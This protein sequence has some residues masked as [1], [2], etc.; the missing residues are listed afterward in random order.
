M[1]IKKLNWEI[2]Y[3]IRE[4]STSYE[5]ELLKEKIEQ[6]EKRFNNSKP[7]EKLY[8]TKKEVMDLCDISSQ[9]TLWNWKKQG[10]LVTRARAGRKPL[11]LR[12]DVLNF[13]NGK[14]ALND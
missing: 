7:A 1:S 8:L 3:G 11:Y 9:S 10:L 14:E 2:P 13:L 12:E 6:L 4:D 5:I